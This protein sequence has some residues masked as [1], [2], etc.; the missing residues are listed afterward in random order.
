MQVRMPECISTVDR[1]CSLIS[2][3]ETQTFLRHFVDLRI[4]FLPTCLISE[5]IHDRRYA[6]PSSSNRKLFLP[7]NMFPLIQEFL[8]PVHLS[9]SLFVNIQLRTSF[10]IHVLFL[11]LKNIE[12]FNYFRNFS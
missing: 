11:K 5:I 2:A 6:C 7:I 1:I 10:P 3:I 9:S 8:K 12:S 4:S